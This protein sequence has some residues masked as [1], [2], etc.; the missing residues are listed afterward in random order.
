MRD[1]ESIA[2]IVGFR[3]DR[4]L[5]MPLGSMD[6]LKIGATVI[7]T[8]NPMKID[9]GYQL[10]GRVLDGLGKPIDGLGDFEKIT[11]KI[12]AL[13]ENINLFLMDYNNHFPYFLVK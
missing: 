3:E 7:N 12:L 2:E 13:N 4:I 10:I 11:S 6:G 8:E 1:A 5:L 9:V